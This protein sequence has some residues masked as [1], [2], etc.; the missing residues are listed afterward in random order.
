MNKSLGVFFTP[1]I[2]SDYMSKEVIKSWYESIDK[3]NIENE[4]YNISVLEPSVG[5]GIFITSFISEF[6]LFCKNIDIELDVKRFASNC[7][8]A[9]DINNDYV[10]HCRNILYNLGCDKD[11]VDKHIIC[12]NTLLMNFRDFD[13]NEG[14]DIVIGNPPYVR[15]EEIKEFKPLLQK[16]KYDVFN[17]TSDLYT[18]FYEQ[19][20][21][22]LKAKGFLSFITS[23]K[24]MR[25]KYGEK[26]RA[27]LKNKT[28]IKNV[29]D[30]GGYKVFDTAT[31]DTN[32]LMFQK[33]INKNNVINVSLIKDNYS[34]G[35]DLSDYCKK[36]NIELSQSS[37]SES[38]FTFAEA[39][40]LK[41]KERIEKIGTPLKDW[42][43][44]INYG[45]KTGF[46]K[47]FIIDGKKKDELIALDPKNAEIIKPILR[48]RDIKKYSYN[49]ADLWLIF[50]PSGWTKDVLGY[51]GK[52]EIE[53]FDIF[54]SKYKALGNYLKFIGDSFEEGKLKAKG[55]GLYKRENK[56]NYWWELS[57]NKDTSFPIEKEKIIYPDITKELSFTNDKNS[58][59]L[60]NTVYYITSNNNTSLNY[61]SSILN[62]KLINFYY[63][64]ISSVLGYDGVRMFTIF[65]ERLP[66]PK[67]S[68]EEMKPFTQ[69]VDKILELK[70]ENKDTS[71]LETKIDKMVY[72]LYS[73]TD[74]EIEIINLE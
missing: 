8:Y 29:I 57:Y 36:N 16:Q 62:S 44:S 42:D 9:I 7:L 14:F 32:I 45:I 52:S 40:V 4:I 51:T 56:G 2:I 1:K 15:Q 5:E 47:A 49:F 23:N 73:L 11:S 22:L 6:I 10:L 20:Y 70:K 3:T 33:D 41:L 60:N 55:K 13:D 39:D 69:I 59:Y 74:E 68:E 31:V 50:I 26:L 48:G 17:S 72:E 18:Y 54:S 12:R 27:F 25:A 43:V 28:L 71:D 35:N 65:V 53:A 19:G 66:I 34:S 58:T 37:L 64:F 30:F 61:L 24:W 67:I 46:N 21:R 38:S 63:S